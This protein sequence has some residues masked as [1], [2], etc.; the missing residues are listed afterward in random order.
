[1]VEAPPRQSPLAHLGL[2]RRT[3]A[4][5]PVW[6]AEDPFRV[7]INL[8][9]DAGKDAFRQAVATALDLALPQVPNTTATAGGRTILWLGPDE[10]LVVAPPNDDGELPRT[11]RQA[12]VGV[13]AAVTDIS[14]ARTVIIVSGPRA[15]DV[16]AKGCALELHPQEFAPGSCAQSTIETLDVIL[17]QTDEVPTYELF[18]HRSFA[19]HLWLWLEDAA[20]EYDG[21]YP[22]ASRA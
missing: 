5:T 11:L 7:Q 18:V 15:R 22:A 9:G 8:R 13:A 19:E 4:A 10:W 1:M 16:L 12:L 20:L 21:G 3:A 2:D 14:E 6:I 17:H